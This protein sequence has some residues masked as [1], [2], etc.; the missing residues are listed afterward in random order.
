MPASLNK[1]TK[2]CL[3][4]SWYLLLTWPDPGDLQCFML[5]NLRGPYWQACQVWGCSIVTPPHSTG[6]H[7]LSWQGEP[8]AQLQ[9][10]PGE[11]PRQTS[12]HHRSQSWL[13]LSKC[14]P[15]SGW[16]FPHPPEGELSSGWVCGWIPGG[17]GVAGSQVHGTKGKVPG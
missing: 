9:V 7:S 16:I 5:G 13:G 8:Q 12:F 6:S 11:W 14:Q 2:R 4:A 1:C 15:E 10:R 3:A 17:G